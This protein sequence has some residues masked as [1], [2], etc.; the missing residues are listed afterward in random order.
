MFRELGI[1]MKLP[2]KLY[3]DSKAALQIASNPV[4]HERTK[5]IDIDCHFIR[6]KI[7]SGLVHTL[8]LSSIEQHADILTKGVRKLKHDHLVSK[9]GLKNIFIQPSLK[10]GIEHMEESG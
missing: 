8:N 2:V 7:Q 3:C 1:E 6:E 9:L 4:F 10:G 5:H